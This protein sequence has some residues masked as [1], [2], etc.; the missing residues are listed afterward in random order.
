MGKQF[1]ESVYSLRL[2][3]WTYRTSFGTVLGVLYGATGVMVTK[4][5]MKHR[6][7]KIESDYLTENWLWNPDKFFL[8]CMAYKD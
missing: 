4:S 6:L 8:D 5:Q 2:F 3:G 1:K 7:A